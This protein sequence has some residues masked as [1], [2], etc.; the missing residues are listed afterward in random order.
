[1]KA[2][3]LHFVVIKVQNVRQKWRFGQ[4][5]CQFIDEFWQE[6]IINV[7]NDWY[8][9]RLHTINSQNEGVL[10]VPNSYKWLKHDHWQIWY[11]SILGCWW[12]WRNDR[13]SSL[14]F[15]VWR[16]IST[17]WYSG[18]LV[19][20]HKTY[21]YKSTEAIKPGGSTTVECR[22]KMSQDTNPRIEVTRETR[23][24]NARKHKVIKIL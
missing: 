4:E 22:Q 21:R 3:D 16:K 7:G 1:M 8:S 17:R 10:K 18:S 20:Y 2:L 15:T 9:I 11:I 24:Q 13:V 5:L 23:S 14:M 12:T 6:P 19:E